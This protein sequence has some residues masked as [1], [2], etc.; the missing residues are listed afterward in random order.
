MFIFS[1]ILVIVSY[2]FLAATYRL[3]DKKNILI[4]SFLSLIS[5]SCAYLLLS[6]WSGCIICLVAVI[7]N[8]V[9]MLNKN[10]SNKKSDYYTLVFLFILIMISAMVTYEGLFSLLS[11]IGVAIYTFSLWQKNPLIYKMLGVPSSLSWILYNIFVGSIFGV[12]L[13][14]LLLVYEG[15]QVIKGLKKNDSN[16]MLNNGVN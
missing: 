12:V 14:G 6:A 16:K 10:S 13:E 11:V 3:N 5:S 7:R 4:T 8:I 2:I 1:Q 15:F 9:F